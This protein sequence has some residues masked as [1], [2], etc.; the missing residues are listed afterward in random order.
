MLKIE[1]VKVESFRK[2][3]PQV[4]SY[5]TGLFRYTKD[6]RIQTLFLI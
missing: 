1:R 3:K 2:N 5:K 4:V 6:G